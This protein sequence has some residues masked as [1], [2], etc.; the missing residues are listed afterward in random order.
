MSSE[1]CKYAVSKP[2][3]EST[4]SHIYAYGIIRDMVRGAF[5]H[6]VILP[7]ACLTVPDRY[8]PLEPK[9]SFETLHNT[10][11]LA[12][13]IANRIMNQVPTLSIAHISSN[14]VLPPGLWQSP[15]RVHACLFS[16]ASRVVF[17]VTKED[18]NQ[19][20]RFLKSELQ[21]LL[22]META[23][24]E[25]WRSRFCIVVLGHFNIEAPQLCDV[26]R[27]REVGWFRDG[28]AL[29]ILSQ[30]LQGK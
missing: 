25:D 20:Q 8:D 12:R 28:M 15:F 30:K 7:V 21:P 27:F 4:P 19:F 6:A 17:L 10:M 16:Q 14:A 29:F 24:E 22:E 26:V 3:R 18:A 1:K 23:V 11:D 5:H 2:S 13:H 9:N